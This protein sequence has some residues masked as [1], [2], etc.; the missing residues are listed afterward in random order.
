M[1]NTAILLISCPDRKGIVAAIANFLYR[2]GANILHADQH[3][4][5]EFGLFFTRIEWDMTDFGLTKENIVK[6]FTPIAGEFRMEW[7]LEYSSNLPKVAILASREKHCLADI[8]YR[9]QNGELPCRIPLVISNHP[10]A[11]DLVKFY[12]LDFAHISTSDKTKERVEKSILELL[13]KNDIDLVILAK[14]MQILSPGFIKRYK[15]KIINIHHS[16]LPAFIGAKPYHQAYS[17]GVKIIG[18]TSHFVTE[19]LDNGPIIEQDIIRISHRDTVERII[20]KG[21]DLE[22]IVLSRA[23]RWYLE[24]RILIY[25]NKTVVFD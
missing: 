3:Q 12:G 17:R 18:A 13:D 9:Y 11:E 2:H 23:V 16:F 4:D 24:N 10:D 14:Y 7:R 22:K 8:L 25:K 21:R 20:Q 15:N 19:E 1:K 5:N 6:K